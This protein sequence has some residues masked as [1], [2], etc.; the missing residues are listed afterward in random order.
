MLLT[1]KNFFLVLKIWIFFDLKLR[2]S[3]AK[4]LSNIF[5]KFC[6]FPPC[7]LDLYTTPLFS[8]SFFL[9]S[10]ILF[11]NIK[12]NFL[13]FQGFNVKDVQAI[14]MALDPLSRT[15]VTPESPVR[16]RA[17]ESAAIFVTSLSL[18]LKFNRSSLM[19]IRCQFNQCFTCG[20]YARRSQKCQMTLLT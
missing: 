4:I 18:K 6:E 20:F 12:Q 7:S 16:I 15:R 8:V 11:I 17:D 1:S 2:K 10:M 9:K 19:S 5:K 3:I 14:S 13:N